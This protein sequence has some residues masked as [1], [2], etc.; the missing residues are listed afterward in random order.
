MSRNSLAFSALYKSFLLTPVFENRKYCLGQ[1]SAMFL[2][3]ST[4]HFASVCLS[5]GKP[6]GLQMPKRDQIG[7]P[8]GVGI[9]Y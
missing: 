6:D 1:I 3:L 5:F 7:K 8:H 9:I 4:V 2:H